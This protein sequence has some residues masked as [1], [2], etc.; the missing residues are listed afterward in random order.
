[1]LHSNRRVS[2]MNIGIDFGT[3]Y[4]WPATV[5]YGSPRTL[6]PLGMD[7]IPSVFYYD[8]QTPNGQPLVGVDAE[9][10]A[11]YQPDNC[12]R[13]IKMKIKEHAEDR[14]I[15]EDR[16]FNKQQIIASI[17][18]E[19]IRIACKKTKEDP[20]S[21]NRP[22]S[23]DRAV[24]S[25]PAAFG[26]QE[27]DIIRSAAQLPKKDGG[28]ELTD[29]SFIKEPVAAAISYFA[30]PNPED[31]NPILVYD[32]GGGTC[33]VA[34]VRPNREN[35]EW[36]DVLATDMMRIGGRDWDK[37]LVEMIA[38]R[39]QKETSK[40]LDTGDVTV[41]NELRREAIKV[42][43]GLSKNDSRT[44]TPCID[45]SY[46]WRCTIKLEEFEDATAELLQRTMDVVDKIKSKYESE[47]N[48][49]VNRIL[50]VGG[51]SKMPQVEKAFK[52]KYGEADILLY[53]PADAIALGSAVFAEHFSDD[54]G[55]HRFLQDISSFSYGVRSVDDYQQYHDRNRMR[56]FNLIYKNKPLPTE[57]SHS[58]SPLDD[59]QE[60]IRYPIFESKCC[61]EKYRPEDGEE[62]GDLVFHNVDYLTSEDITE[63]EMTIDLSGLMHVSAREKKRGR[64]VSVRIDL[65]NIHNER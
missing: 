41:E 64:E 65:K 6:L 27:R 50:C 34:V 32:L 62:I 17:L 19:V 8:T 23:I 2:L 24:I 61:D 25:I 37:A 9:K 7:G 59:H 22:Q 42:K 49:V 29:L 56:V 20:D 33:D 48:D 44:A 16:V 3:S 38:D 15:L 36:Y 11:M 39:Y 58:F 35:E 55:D 51:S 12:V 4:S 60:T 45:G 52:R 30:E 31:D 47:N 57:G 18:Q 63:V 54:G 43:H 10:R 40:T 26:L 21:Y 1:M 53:R 14:F 13:E 46:N 5:A 28:P